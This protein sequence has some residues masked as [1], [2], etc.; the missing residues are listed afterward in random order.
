MRLSSAVLAMAAILAP[1][2]P[3]R[4]LADD[5]LPADS[6]VETVIDHYVDAL[7]SADKVE[8]AAQ[9]D[10]L[11]LLR[12]LML[13]LAGRIPTTVE[14]KQFRDDQSQTKRQAL[15]DQLLASPDF[16]FHHRNEL[17]RELLPDNPGDGDFR[18]YL[19]WAAQQN[20]P[21]NQM[22]EDMVVGDESDEYQKAGMQFLR[23]RVGSVDDLTNDTS[24]LFFGVN[25]SCAQ[26]HD[27]PLADDWKQDHYFGMQSFFS[28]TYLTKSKTLAEKFYG[29]VKFKTTKGVEKQAR[30]MFLNGS[31][32]DEPDRALSDDERKKLDEEV[33][34]LQKDDNAKPRKPD[35]SPRSELVKLALNEEGASFFARNIANR[36]WNRLFGQGIVHPPDQLHSGNPASHPQL[37][38]WLARD[39]R[40]HGYDLK[41]LI[42]GIALSRAY[43]R[44]SR[45]E[46]DSETPAAYYFALAQPRILTPRQY[47][48][49]LFI[50][51]Q[52]PP[53]WD[54]WASKPPED[55]AKEREKL[56][57]RTDGWFRMFEP[58]TA[59]YQVPVDEA[60]LFSNSSQIQDDLLRDSADRLLGHLKG[61]DDPSEAI[62]AAFWA[63]VSRPPTD[64]EKQSIREYLKS[65]T[66]D[67][68][69][70]M[71]QVLWALI[72]GPEVRFN[73]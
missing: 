10:D 8:P 54:Q 12:R 26:C 46:S 14:A 69:A 20:R 38:K 52:N 4:I 67:R 41:R 27:H 63:I 28:R 71:K 21:W 56:E 30:F 68:S 5:L 34:T 29:D 42:R 35:F 11:N 37:L 17:D 65:R 55:W 48:I 47:S 36:V 50:A 70:A 72:S 73:Y 60:L 24:I 2:V 7:L 25:V 43:S 13:D 1:V 39:L 22:F 9:V 16:A 40:T 57:Q 53:H 61:I 51:S 6:A 32:S 49:S 31:V 19:L 45:W 15:V 3:S 23:T 64:V 58:P 33:K 62:D 66:E 44:S 59:N 18:K